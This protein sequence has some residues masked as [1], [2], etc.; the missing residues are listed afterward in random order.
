MIVQEGAENGRKS[1]QKIKILTTGRVTGLPHIVVVRFVFSGGAF[2]VLAGKSRS[3]WVLNAVAAGRAKL[4][5]RDLVYDAAV[6]ASQV[7]ERSS[8][9][10]LFSQ[11]YGKRLTDE[12]YSRSEAELTLTPVGTAAHRGSPKG[13]NQVSTS[14]SEWR[15]MG[16]DYYSWIARAFDSAS[17]EYDFTIKSNFINRWIRERSIS[18][19]LSY[20]KS[21]DVLLE[22][23]CGTGAEAL[24]ISKHVGGVV[25]TD[26]SPAMINLLSRKIAAR[27]V[28]A[29]V[30][31]KQAGASRIS[32]VA[33][34]LPG[35]KSRVVYSFNGALNCEPDVE[36]VPEEL[37]HI[38]GDGGF[39]ICSIRNSLCVPEAL[40]HAAVLQFDKMAPRKRQPVMVS[41]GG[42][43]IPS[44]YYAP[45]KFARLFSPQFKLR[46]M[47]GL[48]S[49][50]PP[51]YLSD[52]YFRT[53]TLLSFA[54][55][56]ESVVAGRYP[57]NR[58]GDQ[59]LLV[60]QKA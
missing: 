18:V 58:F 25:A 4:R 33:P 26:I 34:M 9:L 20:T 32:E 50:L 47:I 11:K 38:V 14:F 3:D 13:E 12:W 57:F 27:K 55:R 6:A 44:Y 29:K 28:A 40:V 54:E 15:S 21:E 23:G 1:E 31:A 48:P 7:D 60:F 42:M 17:E 46:R 24:E 37:S 59:T 43:D 45:M 5:L 36:K 22:I 35:G 19:L 10:Q 51:A 39:F 56:V 49:I 53:R 2:H 30:I 52:L 16:D 41:V 8:T